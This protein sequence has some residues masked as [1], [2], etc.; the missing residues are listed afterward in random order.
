M[1]PQEAFVQPRSTRRSSNFGIS[2]SGA[3]LTSVPSATSAPSG[4]KL[5]PGTSERSLCLYEERSDTS[6]NVAVPSR[7][8]TRPLSRRR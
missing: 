8:S 7:S 6:W 4:M 2:D 3:D 5:A 1:S